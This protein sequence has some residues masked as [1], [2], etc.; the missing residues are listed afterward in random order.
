MSSTS[1]SRS[2]DAALVAR[3]YAVE[4]LT[5]RQIAA[6]VGRS[7]TAVHRALIRSGIPRR[8]RGSTDRRIPADVRERVLNAYLDGA[9][10]ADICT[11]HGISS[12]SV[13]NIVAD[14]GYDLRPAGG[15][16]HLDLSAIDKLGSQ[17]WPPAAVAMLTGFSEGHVRRQ[18]RKLGYIRQP[19][20][21]TQVLAE[22]LKR[23]GSLRAVARQLGCSAKRVKTALEKEG[24]Q[25]PTRPHRRAA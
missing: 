8:G 3:L 22:M 24:V 18:M 1:S 17:G 9:A 21:E 10:M 4:Q 5:V 2:I 14:A 20:P 19:L 6:R 13:R 11:D 16:Q 15:R 23:H 25:V 7:H 12:Q